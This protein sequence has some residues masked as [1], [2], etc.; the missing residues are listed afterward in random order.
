MRFKPL[1][2]RVLQKILLYIVLFWL[3]SSALRAAMIF[4]QAQ[5][6][7]QEI[8]IMV[9]TYCMPLLA[10]SVWSIDPASTQKMM[11]VIS[12]LPGIE[13]VV[14]HT[15]LGET[16]H[17]GSPVK[18]G[19]EQ[20]RFV[21]DV[22]LAQ[23][24]HES[25]GK[26]SVYTSGAAMRHSI[27]NMLISSGLQRLL[28]FVVLALLIIFMMR[29]HYVLP[30]Q[31]LANSIRAFRPGD[32]FALSRN[33][34]EARDEMSGLTEALAAMRTG[35]NHHQAEQTRFVSALA[36]SRDQLLSAQAL[37]LALSTRFNNT[38]Q[39]RISEA[40]EQALAK[41]GPHMAADCCYLL[42]VDNSQTPRLLLNW[43][44]AQAGNISDS[45]DPQQHAARASLARQVLQEGTVSLHDPDR[46]SVTRG[47]SLLMVRIDH[48]DRPVGIIGCDRVLLSRPWTDA[49]IL[50]LRL[51]A[52]LFANL[53][54]HR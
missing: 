5:K 17:D 4:Q 26:L 41:I 30:M 29:R 35:I 53:L 43:Y 37:T 32:T 40:V 42:E 39:N 47:S 3:L 27:A 52:T 20:T 38:P 51:L 23:G 21:L 48:Q 16:F 18:P 2:L 14:L 33:K 24:S 45:L 46:E 28:D 31:Q 22:Q 44:S 54:S 25:L 19:S 9:K 36:S 49:D 34:T 8:P 50:V 10:Q 11:M 13:S 15:T 7:M 1:A 6:K 12:A